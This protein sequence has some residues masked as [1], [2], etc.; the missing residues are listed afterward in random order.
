MPGSGRAAAPFA[1]A[2]VSCVNLGRSNGCEC[3]VLEIPDQPHED[4]ADGSGGDADGE[5]DD[6]GQKSHCMGIKKPAR[7]R[8]AERVG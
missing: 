2:F 8:E 6:Y 4:Y 5:G 3:L 7:P 1:K